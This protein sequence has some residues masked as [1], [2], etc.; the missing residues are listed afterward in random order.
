MERFI[1]Y[2]DKPWNGMF[3]QKA[4]DIRVAPIA[5]DVMTITFFGARYR[6]L[7]NLG[8]NQAGRSMMR[9]IGIR[10]LGDST[11]IQRCATNAGTGCARSW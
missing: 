5:D 4:M 9:G 2:L 6:K 1:G 8:I 3:S 11:I 7:S 10:P